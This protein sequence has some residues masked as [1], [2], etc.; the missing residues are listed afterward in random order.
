MNSV[1]NSLNL[2]N[3]GSPSLHFQ[4]L[5][6][7]QCVQELL[8]NETY[9]AVTHNSKADMMVFW[10]CTQVS[11]GIGGG[12]WKRLLATSLRRGDV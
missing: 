6:L 5:R 3:R 9:L 11:S 4:T 8:G 7:V 10:I 1:D 12:T 2:V